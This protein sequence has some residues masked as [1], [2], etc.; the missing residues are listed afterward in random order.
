MRF[1]ERS[2]LGHIKVKCEATSADV[3]ASAN[4]AEDLTKIINEAGYTKQQICNIDKTA[5]TGRCHLGLS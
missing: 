2:C 1:E 5:S 3:E 4:Y